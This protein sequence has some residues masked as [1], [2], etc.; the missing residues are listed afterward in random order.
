MARSRGEGKVRVA[1]GRLT[2]ASGR[3]ARQKHGPRTRRWRNKDGRWWRPGFGWMS[4]WRGSSYGRLH[5]PLPRLP[6][7]SWRRRRRLLSGVARTMFDVGERGSA[8]CLVGHGHGQGEAFGQ[9]WC[10][11]FGKDRT[12]RGYG[13]V[14]VQPCGLD[15]KVVH[16]SGCPG[17]LW[18]ALARGTR[19]FSVHCDTV[20]ARAGLGCRGRVGPRRWYSKHAIGVA[21]GV[22]GLGLVAAR[23]VFDEMPQRAGRDCDDAA[24]FVSRRPWRG[25]ASL[26][27]CVSVPWC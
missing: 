5:F 7:S 2:R 21:L 22:R 24:V 16:R 17:G 8:A 4:S 15:G 13:R 11:G 12:R 26:R 18:C 23:K 27:L 19:A 9:L 14:R 10:E 20:R 1:G 25:L 6:V 3:K